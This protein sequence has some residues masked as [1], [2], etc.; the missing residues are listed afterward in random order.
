MLKSPTENRI[1]TSLGFLSTVCIFDGPFRE[2]FPRNVI[3]T[4]LSD[5]SLILPS[6]P[7]MLDLLYPESLNVNRTIS[8][9]T[10]FLEFVL[11][12]GGFTARL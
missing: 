12:L 2:E 5:A 7:V 11:H 10:G 4:F 3:R 8:L 6:F 9:F 1:L